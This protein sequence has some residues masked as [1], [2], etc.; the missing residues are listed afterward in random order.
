L[1]AVYLMARVVNTKQLLEELVLLAA[2]NPLVLPSALARAADGTA[3]TVGAKAALGLLREAPHIDYTHP[4]SAPALRAMVRYAHAAGRPEE[5]EARIARAIAKDPDAAVFHEIRGLHL[6]LSGAAE[7]AET[8]Y[9]RALEI[10][11]TSAEALSGLARL[12]L[13]AEPAEAAGLFEQAAAADP[14]NAELQLEAARALHASGR[15]REAK[16]HLLK[17]L[18]I[19]PLESEAA[20][21]LTALDL[22]REQVTPQTLA[23]ARTAAR[24]GGGPDAF[25]RLSTVYTRLGQNDQAAKTAEHAKR[26]RERPDSAGEAPGPES[27][28]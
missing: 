25:D 7:P 3:E 21:E 16:E 1:V 11:P 18:E 15:A 19:D 4:Y 10:A 13:E 17:A 5:A 23:W 2:R 9:A 14:T 27:A 26:L 24:L 8:A 6:E 22:A 20:A 12:K 28:G